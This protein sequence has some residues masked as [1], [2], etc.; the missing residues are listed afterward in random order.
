MA[1]YTINNGLA[2]TK[3]ALSGT[4]KTILEGLA[5][6]TGIKRLR[7]YGYKMAAGGTYASTDTYITFDIPRATATATAT[8]TTPLPVDPNDGAATSA[9]KGNATAEG[10][11]TATS[12]LDLITLNQRAQVGWQT[13]DQSQMLVGPATN[14]AGLIMRALS[15][16]YTGTVDVTVMFNE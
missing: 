1:N 3:Q 16:G 9:W 7:W 2:G 14:N 8:A 13:N 15:G 12:S 11:V 10:T 4:A 6:T 5:Q